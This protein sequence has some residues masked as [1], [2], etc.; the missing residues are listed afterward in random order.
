M[1]SASRSSCSSTSV[2]N[3]GSSLAHFF[4]AALPRHLNVGLAGPDSSLPR[5]EGPLL[6]RGG[7]RAHLAK[8][9]NRVR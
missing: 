2:E 6:T 7:G 4:I 9:L 8:E 3:A 5:L 1:L